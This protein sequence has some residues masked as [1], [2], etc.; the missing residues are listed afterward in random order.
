MTYVCALMSEKNQL[1]AL[2]S[3]LQHL[4]LKLFH[5][6]GH[7][8]VFSYQQ[9]EAPKRAELLDSYLTELAYWA[10]FCGLT[11]RIGVGDSPVA[12]VGQ[13]EY[14]PLPD[15]LLPMERLSRAWAGSP[16]EIP[17]VKDLTAA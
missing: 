13:A 10:G 9:E 12:A 7:H 8:L 16:I 4:P 2:L 14:G 1:T 5:A 11:V 15:H 3:G 17:A 6:Q